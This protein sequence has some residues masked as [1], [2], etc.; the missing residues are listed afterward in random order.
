MPVIRRFDTTL[1]AGDLDQPCTIL[2]PSQRV[3]EAL[4]TGFAT[5]RST[6][7]WLTPDINAIDVW[8]ET[9]WLRLSNQGR[10]PFAQQ[11]LLNSTE[12]SCIWLTL[13]EQTLKSNPL[14][15]V[16]EAATSAQRAYQTFRLWLD[17]GSKE[18]ALPAAA[19]IPELNLFRDWSQKF[20]E[21]CRARN[22]TSLADAT[23]T[24]IRALEGGDVVLPNS[25][26]MVNFYQPPPLYSRLFQLLSRSKGSRIIETASGS[27]V[28]SGKKYRFVDFE[29]ECLACARWAKALLEKNPNQHIGIIFGGD[30]KKRTLIERLFVD[31]FSPQAFIDI[32]NRRVPFNTTN[33]NVSITESGLITDALL[34]LSLGSERL[35][36]AEFCRLLQSPHLLGCSEESEQRILLESH[37]R[38]NLNTTCS[39]SQL[40][41]IMS[42]QDQPYHCPLLASAL[43]K[44]SSLMRENR[45]LQTAAF[46]KQ[47]FTRQLEVL[48]WPGQS[49]P[50]ESGQSGLL[51]QWQQILIGFAKLDNLLPA[52]DRQ[53]A[54]SRLR[55]LCQST[56][57]HKPFQAGCPL[58]LYSLTEA[59]GLEFDHV[60]FLAF[61]DQS[62]PPPPQPSPF[63]LHSIQRAAQVPGSHSDV[64]LQHAQ[65][66]FR[67]VC[68]STA[69][70]LHA[71]YHE[72]NGDESFRASS[73]IE[74]FTPEIL[75]VA[76]T[77]PLNSL[78][79]EA[80]RGRTMHSL[81]E[82]P[83]VPLAPGAE[84]KGGQAIVSDQS[85]C[86]F[87]AFANHRLQARPVEIF[88]NGLSPRARGTALHIA[89]EKLF[90]EIQSSDSL[91]SLSAEQLSTL[92]SQCVEPALTFLG[93]RFPELMTPRFSAIE[94]HRLNSLIKDYLALEKQR[95]DFQVVATEQPVSWQS[96]QIRINLKIDRI[97]RLDNGALAV[98]DY[99]SGKSMPNVRKLLDARPENLQLPVYHRAMQENRGEP[100]EA[101]ILAQL[102]AAK[103]GFTG[104][105]ADNNFHSSIKAVTEQRDFQQDWNSLTLHWQGIL[106]QFSSEF[107]QGIARVDPVNRGATCTHC[108]LQP[109]CR[110]QELQPAEV[111]LDSV[112]G[113]GQ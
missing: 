58:S 103:T 89:L 11:R 104:L 78:A 19:G 96:G 66:A 88:S 111:G 59:A 20:V 93:S 29:A 4:L 64:Q 2:V 37:L 16:N 5:D 82:E 63:L 3:R 25:I 15:N 109:L 70:E 31:T 45:Q 72:Q 52:I 105:A 48:G 100:V 1:F 55:T 57:P 40:L 49:L 73:L 80:C 107:E 41:R 112:A 71:S 101:L 110:I 21:F 67:I 90:S 14:L 7:S 6:S 60:W 69:G 61:S 33:S 108:K 32:G 53:T 28:F 76:R 99:K 56:R 17:D 35:D 74:S 62:Q 8:I 92:V 22:L 87:R 77:Q 43:L 38:E 85:S 39:L 51:Q 50:P 27:S 81:A 83:A 84:I 42:R 9:Q 34:L 113:D 26:V 79:A 65:Q 12:E 46:W 18:T 86:P 47:F 23:H 13:I 10:L 30:E 54:L 44:F 91:Q 94:R 36:S 102:N 68:Q 75:D 95:P 106:Q 24:L 97:D 98:I